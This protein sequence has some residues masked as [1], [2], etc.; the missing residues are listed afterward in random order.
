MT[1]TL[2]MVGCG[3]HGQ[4]HLK[5]FDAM[6][7]VQLVAAVDQDPERAR[8]AATQ[9]G[10]AGRYT[11]VREMLERHTPD[12]VSLALP[13]EASRESVLAALDA[14]AHVLVAKPL[15]MNVGEAQELIA[16]TRRR[17]KTMA[18]ALQNRCV[19]EVRALRAFLAA[20]KLGRLFHAR[21]WHGHVLNI[22]GTPTMTRRQL[23]GGGVVFHTMVHLLDATL[24]AM[25]NPTP[26]RSKTST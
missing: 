3:A 19:S 9:F 20:G 23:A 11:D 14:G 10:A 26:A 16:A 8:R 12:L 21:L 5:A 2:G 15:A 6:P 17:G 4:G 24:W 18:M 7:D 1:L 22:P 13:P 25:G